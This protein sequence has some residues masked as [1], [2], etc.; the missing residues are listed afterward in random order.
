MEVKQAA[1]ELLQDMNGRIQFLLDTQRDPAKRLLRE[2]RHIE[3]QNQ[4]LG[5]K[6][7]EIDQ[8]HQ[9]LRKKQEEIAQQHQQLREKRDKI[10][11][12]SSH[13]A[14]QNEQLKKQQEELETRK[15]QLQQLLQTNKKLLLFFVF[16]KPTKYKFQNF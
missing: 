13:V 8:L 3:S 4:Q 15:T 6:Q 16:Y 10:V 9:Q 12:L 2:I 14:S 1:D 11:Q 7:E 5:E